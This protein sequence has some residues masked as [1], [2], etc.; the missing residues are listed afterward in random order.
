MR[1]RMRV[2]RWV[3]GMV[4]MGSFAAQAHAATLAYRLAMPVPA[5]HQFDVTLDIAASA[6]APELVMPAWTPGYYQLMHYA[7]AVS[8]FRA[9]DAHGRALAWVREGDRWRV[10]NP[11]HTAVTV[12]YRVLADHE[13]VANNFLGPEKGYVVPAGVFMYPQGGLDQPVDL[14]VERYAN[15]TVATGL[16]GVPGQPGRYRAPDFDT[17]YDSPLLMGN[18]KYLPPF[19]IRGVRHDVAGL[20]LDLVDGERLVADLTKIVHAATDLIGEVPYSHYVFLDIGKGR[21]GIEHLNSSA[22]GLGTQENLTDAGRL[23]LDRFL[24]HE[25]FHNFNV[26]R[27]RPVELGPFDYTQPNRTRQL[28][29]SEGLTVYYEDIVLRRAGLLDRATLLENMSHAMRDYE[30]APGHAFQSLAQASYETWEDGP[31][32]RTGDAANQTISYYDKGPVVGFMLDL[33]I[34]HASAN[35]HSLDDVMRMLYREYYRG[36]QRGFTGAE[37]QQICERMAGQSLTELFTYVDTT[38]APDYAHYFSMAGLTLDTTEQPAPH[39][40][41]DKPPVSG[42]RGFLISPAASPDALQGAILQSF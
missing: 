19:F 4:C 28:W 14:T 13:F 32:G 31:F 39:P 24:A 5:S 40:A 37:F 30:N 42:E 22:V 29:I 27:I 17:L 16:D 6:V 10:S 41:D 35:Q 38:A 9:S 15:W 34:R 1:Q 18:L 8:D 7:D 36:R 2:G 33:A 3:V 20:D 23:K 11:G 21:G 12:H 26:K 25:Y